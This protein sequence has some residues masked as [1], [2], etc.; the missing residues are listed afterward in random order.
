M[1]LDYVKKTR[2]LDFVKKG[3]RVEQTEMKQ[4]GVI[5]GGN[6]SGNIDVK[7]DGNKHTDNCHPTYMMKYFDDNGNVIKEYKD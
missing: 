1:N 4:S 2:G 7:F 6:R 5:V 3:M